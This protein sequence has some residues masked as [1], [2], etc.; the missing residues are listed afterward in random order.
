MLIRVHALLDTPSCLWNNAYYLSLDDSLSLVVLTLAVRRPVTV[1]SS[2]GSYCTAPMIVSQTYERV[3]NMKCMS[4]GFFQ[5]LFLLHVIKT[6]VCIFSLYFTV[7]LKYFDNSKRE[8]K[9]YHVF[10]KKKIISIFCP[11]IF[12]P[13]IER[14]TKVFIGTSE[15][16]LHAAILLYFIAS[17]YRCVEIA[18][19]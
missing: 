1:P 14:N 6:L 17:Y 7:Q 5:L 3:I 11:I 2:Q 16:S 15:N 12:V 10:C 19:W 9:E 8:F 4:V 13:F 18:N